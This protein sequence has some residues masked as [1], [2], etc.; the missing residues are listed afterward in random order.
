[1]R[2]LMTFMLGLAIVT[3]TTVAVFADD[4]KDTTKKEKKVKKTK[5]KKT[6]EEKK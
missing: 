5:A 4:A 3:G 1:M 2:K 6:T